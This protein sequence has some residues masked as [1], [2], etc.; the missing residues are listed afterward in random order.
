[1]VGVAQLVE[2][3]LVV[4]EVAGSSPVVHP[5]SSEGPHG[6]PSAR[7]PGV[8]LG[9]ADHP[10]CVK[11]TIVIVYVV[12]AFWLLVSAATRIALQLASGIALDA[13]PFISGALGIVAILLLLPAYE[14]WRGDRR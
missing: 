3:W 5:I 2:R 10:G 13:L 4:P 12:M 8:L 11:A 1:M 7:V 14:D 6:R 9:F